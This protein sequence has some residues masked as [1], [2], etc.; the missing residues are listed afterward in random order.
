[1]ISGLATSDGDQVV[2]Q[3][4][5]RAL[6]YLTYAY[7][8]IRPYCELCSVTLSIVI[9]QNY[10]HRKRRQIP[11]RSSGTGVRDRLGDGNA[12]TINR[13]T[14]PLRMCTNSGQGENI[15]VNCYM[16]MGGPKNR[17]VAG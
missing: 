16:R 14:L 1:M 9:L 8:H 10:I 13:R 17:L 6:F 11:V 15:S 3:Q 5:L 4:A 12:S 2:I 7:L